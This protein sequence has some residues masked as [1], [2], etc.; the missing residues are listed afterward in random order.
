MKKIFSLLIFLILFTIFAKAQSDAPL[1]SFKNETTLIL[2]DSSYFYRWSD[3]TNDWTFNTKYI[4]E[5]D[6]EGLLKIFYITYLINNTMII[7][8]YE[9]EYDINKNCVLIMKYEW[10]SDIN[11]WVKSYKHTYEYNASGKETLNTSF[12]WS[13]TN[14][15]INSYKTETEYD[16]NNNMTARSNYSYKSNKWVGEYLQI[17][18]YDNNGNKTLEVHNTFDERTNNWVGSFRFVYT[19]DNFNNLLSYAQYNWSTTTNNWDKCVK[20]VYEYDNNQNK[21]TEY[22]YTGVNNIW[23]LGHKFVNEYDINIKTTTF[24]YI[25]V[26]NEYILNGKTIYNYNANN[27]LIN[28]THYNG[29]GITWTQLQK[30]DY[31]YDIYGNQI[32]E[33]ACI[34][35]NSYWVGNQKIV[36]EYDANKNLLLEAYYTWLGSDWIGN[37]KNVYY[38]SEHI[39]GIQNQKLNDYEIKIYPNPTTNILYLNNLTEK[40]EIE[41]FDLNGKLVLKTQNDNNQINVSDLNSGIYT[42]R[43]INKKGINTQKFVKE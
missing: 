1:N 29:D 24:V 23:E 14:K 21:I 20:Y 40:S 28:E 37:F 27:L 35:L 11:E 12:R 41:I 19:F 5:Y 13:S 42:I 6:N 25:L 34:W 43:I 22:D 4:N 17:Y 15:W 2:E 7:N 36:H 9:N 3:I 30:T 26:N 38:L 31:D 32:F 18:E 16:L 39:L 10:K 8:R 33:A